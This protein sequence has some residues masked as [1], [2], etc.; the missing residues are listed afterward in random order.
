[1]L[2][3][4]YIVLW[5][6]QSNLFSN[7]FS[8]QKAAVGSTGQCWFKCKPLMLS[9]EDV[10]GD[11]TFFSVL[12]FHSLGLAALRNCTGKLQK[13]FI[14]NMI[15][16]TRRIRLLRLSRAPLRKS[17]ICSSPCRE[18]NLAVSEMA[19]LY[20]SFLM[21]FYLNCLVS[22]LTFSYWSLYFSFQ[23]SSVAEKNTPIS[24]TLLLSCSVWVWKINIVN[25]LMYLLAVTAK[26]QF[27]SLLK[28]SMS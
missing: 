4:E 2:P 20:K 26:V 22:F 15:K 23:A 19:K 16:S 12:E 14:V 28:L 18:E 10:V 11:W 24:I 5:L 9:I 17:W 1:M 7:I 27:S 21:S 25:L 6:Y 3:R 13:Y 8:P